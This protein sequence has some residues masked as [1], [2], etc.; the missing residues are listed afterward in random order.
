MI[1]KMQ[2]NQKDIFAKDRIIALLTSKLITYNVP[3]LDGFNDLKKRTF[4]S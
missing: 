1:K 4:L 3:T 2:L